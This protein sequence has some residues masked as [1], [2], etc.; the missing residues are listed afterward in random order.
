LCIRPGFKEPELLVDA[1][2]SW[3][4][5]PFDEVSLLSGEPSLGKIGKRVWKR[6]A[7]RRAKKR[8]KSIAP[9]EVF[10][11]GDVGPTSQAVLHF[12]RKYNEEATRTY[13]EDGL[14]AY[15]TEEISENYFK[16]PNTFL[17]KIFYGP[18]WF[19]RFRFEQ[20]WAKGGTDRVDRV[21]ATFPDL[22]REELA[23]KPVEGIS[24]APLLN[25]EDRSW[26]GSYVEANGANPELFKDIEALVLLAHSNDTTETYEQLLTNAFEWFEANDVPFGVKFHPLENRPDYVTVP[27]H[28][29][30]IPSAVPVE[31]LYL[32]FPETIEY[33]VGRVSTA[34]LSAKWLLD[35]PTVLSLY[36]DAETIDPHVR[37]VFDE[38]GIE[39]L[40]NVEDLELAMT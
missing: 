27:D 30:N 18:L 14:I 9:S 10:V 28:A 1:I 37:F 5:S 25:L 23:E 15:S 12:S 16:Q 20:T 19:R 35:D 40:E 3:D 34:Q 4:E 22:V 7:S 6:Q 13:V 8:I 39:V 24:P 2:A 32:M 11:F 17:E 29:T 31:L 33:L 38:L 36:P 21:R 26:I